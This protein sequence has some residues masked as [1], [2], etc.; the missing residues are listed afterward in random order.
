MSPG[1]ALQHLLPKQALTSL[2]GWLA[3]ARGGAATTAAIRAFVQRY[4]V[5]LA[6]RL[7]AIGQVHEFKGPSRR[8][9]A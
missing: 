4:G 7:R 6:D 8:R 1:I 3:G 9:S 5:R 2:M